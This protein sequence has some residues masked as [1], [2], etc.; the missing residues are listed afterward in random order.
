MNYQKKPVILGLLCNLFHFYAFSL[1]LF[2]AI[3]LSPIFFE[4]DDLSV[5]RTLGLLTICLSL[6]VKPLGAIIF[7]YIGDRCGTQR[8]L[9]LSLVPMS[10][11]T[12]CIGLIPS[13]E[14][15]GSFSGIL[16]IICLFM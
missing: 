8:V 5:T 4:A 10:I 11:A 13:V 1:Y 6:L 14:I 12:A 7:G 3:I 15:L 2:S 9:I 16:L